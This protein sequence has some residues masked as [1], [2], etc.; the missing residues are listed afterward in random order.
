M[1]TEPA[2][3]KACCNPALKVNSLLNFPLK[4]III[5]TWQNLANFYFVIETTF[6]LQRTRAPGRFYSPSAKI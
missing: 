1:Q 6:V 4:K 3:L 5:V 2:F